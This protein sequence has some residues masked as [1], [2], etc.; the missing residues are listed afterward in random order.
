MEVEAVLLERGLQLPQ[1]VDLPALARRDLVARR[2]DVHLAAAFLLGDVA[3]RVRGAEQVL[4]GGAVAADLDEPDADP[5]LEHL[6]LPDEAEVPHGRADVIGDLAR[7]VERAAEQQHAELVAA[8]SCHGVRLA[9]LLADQRGDAAQQAVA[10][11]VAAGVVH[12]L[13][14]VE[15]QVAE[16]VGDVLLA[17][18]LQRLLEAP[19][20]LAPVDEA[21]QRVVGR[22]VAHA[23]GQA[24][25]LRDVVHDHDRA[26]DHVAGALDRRG[27]QLDGQLLAAGLGQHHGAPPHVDAAPVGEA[28]LDRV[29][30]V[31]PVGLVDEPGDVGQALADG[32]LAQARQSASRRRCSC[33]R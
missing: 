11:D 22:L 23:L 18:G 32:V 33:S 6:V 19:L 25:D 7:L 10:G 21:G 4:D 17:H 28:A 20:E 14:A 3:G 29:A 30:E 13:E 15:V 8:E 5:D 16:H 1:P 24:A 2:V 27:G 31:A 26:G 9:D 12:R